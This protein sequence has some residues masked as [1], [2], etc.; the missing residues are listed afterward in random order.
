MLWSPKEYFRKRRKSLCLPETWEAHEEQPSELPVFLTPTRAQ[1]K[2]LAWKE[3]PKQWEIRWSGSGLHERPRAFAADLDPKRFDLDGDLVEPVLARVCGGAGEVQGHWNLVSWVLVIR[4]LWSKRQ[5]ISASQLFE[6][7]TWYQ[8][9]NSCCD[10]YFLS[11]AY[12]WTSSFTG[13]CWGK[14]S[15]PTN[16]E[17]LFWIRNGSSNYL[18]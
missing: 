3:L 15:Q 2:G 10:E 12:S 9:K 18:Y 7:W 11:S 1:R 17:D 13:F 6:I 16:L 14:K 5:F 8:F 4:D